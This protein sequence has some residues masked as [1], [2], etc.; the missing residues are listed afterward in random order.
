MRCSFDLEMQQ[1]KYDAMSK[2]ILTFFLSCLTFSTV[3]GRGRTRHKGVWFFPPIERSK[4][5]EGL[6]RSQ[7][8]YI[9]RIWLRAAPTG[10]CIVNAVLEKLNMRKGD[11][12]IDVAGCSLE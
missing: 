7:I 11:F 1:F 12:Y 2:W 3:I 10:T 6:H 8:Q 9:F 5:S 4:M